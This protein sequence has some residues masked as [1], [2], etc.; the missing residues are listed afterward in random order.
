MIGYLKEMAAVIEAMSEGDLSC[1]VRPRSKSDTLG[2]AFAAMTDGLRRL[3]RSVREGATQ[4]AGGSNKVAASS[5]DSAKVSVH[6]SSA[7]EEVTSTMHEM[8][9]NV[10]N[11]VKS[12]QMQASSVSETSA[13]MDQMVMSIQRVADTCQVLL[14][15][16]GRSRQEVRNGIDSMQKADDGLNRINSSIQMASEIITVLGQRADSIGTIIE[17]ID[18]L[19]EQTNLLALNAAIEAARAGERGL[20]FAV[21]ADEVRKLAEK[22]AQST[23]EISG[24]IQGIQ[25]ESH[26]A[27][28]NMKKSATIV[29]EGLTLGT[30]LS[31]AL[32][33]I[34]DVVAEVYK[35]AEEISAA[36]NEQSHGSSEITKA[37]TRLNEIAHEIDSSVE[38]QAVG[39]Q[40]V[41]NA[42]ERMRELVQ[43]SSFS[44]AELAT[45][46]DEMSKMAQE[47][48]TAVGQ[49][50][51]EAG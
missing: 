18:D 24:L 29:K 46:A 28:D 40:A 32:K 30:T 5:G 15:I 17:V 43:Q 48:M 33:K 16:S 25:Q 42:M 51:L 50:K 37:T 39:A 36:T 44:S 49:F 14:E 12:T 20:G 13:S 45:S 26:R 27:V 34:S 7:I 11:V 10:Q 22:S 9:V 31:T 3:V 6:A 4:L 8:S 21:V 47:M 2:H 41:V 23:K 1:E 35:F 38:E 19:A